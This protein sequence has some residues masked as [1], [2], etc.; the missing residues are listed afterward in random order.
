MKRLFVV[1]LSYCVVWSV[2]FSYDLRLTEVLVDGSDE[3]VEISNMS[4]DPFAGNLTLSGAKSSLL[5]LNSISIP[6]WSSLIVGDSL[7]M[8]SSY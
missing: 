4:S 1:M 3:F 5:T 6:A 7:A 8:L 2:V